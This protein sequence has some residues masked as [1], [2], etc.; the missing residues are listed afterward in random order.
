MCSLSTETR[1]VSIRL[2]LSAAM[3][4]PTQ[5]GLPDFRGT[6]RRCSRTVVDTTRIGDCS[7]GVALSGRRLGV[8]CRLR[9]YAITIHVQARCSIACQDE[10]DMRDC[11]CFR[12][13]SM[14][15]SRMPYGSKVYLPP[16][17][18][19]GLANQR[20]QQLNSI[21]LPDW[22]SAV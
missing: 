14:S 2:H 3:N 11:R 1:L 7:S 16:D 6:E 21:H 22:K 15:Y 19:C 8:P 5:I 10:D 9:N 12:H 13:F 17:R 20:T 18:P 4:V